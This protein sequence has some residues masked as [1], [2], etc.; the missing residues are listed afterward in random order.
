[1][2]GDRAM[3]KRLA[4]RCAAADRTGGSAVLSSTEPTSSSGRGSGFSSSR[5]HGQI[6]DKHLSLVIAMNLFVAIIPLLILGYAF[7]EAFKS[8]SELRRRRCSCLPSDRKHIAIRKRRMGRGPKGCTEL[9][10]ERRT[11]T[12]TA[13]T[14]CDEPIQESRAPSSG[15]ATR[16]PGDSVVILCS[17]PVWPTGSPN[18]AVAAIRLR[19]VPAYSRLPASQGTRS[20]TNMRA[21]N[22]IG[23]IFQTAW[24]AW[25]SAVRS[26]DGR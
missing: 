3:P 11:T 18:R 25:R 4:R 12:A 14:E 21:P 6:G 13:P 20:R 8:T 5:R 23:S 7:L 19:V 9:P 16:L 22:L 2:R 17:G 26:A 15:S 24:P 10:S 1:M